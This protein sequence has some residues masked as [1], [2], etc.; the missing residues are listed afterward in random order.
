MLLSLS[1]SLA[2][3]AR[4]A[5]EYPWGLVILTYTWG[6]C[7]DPS[8]E[9]IGWA[10]SRPVQSGANWNPA[11]VLEQLHQCSVCITFKITYLLF[12]NLMHKTETGTARGERLLIA[13]HLDQLNHL[14]NKQ[15]VLVFAVPSAGFSILCKNAV[16]KLFCWAKLACFD[17]SS[18]KI[19]CTVHCWC[20]SYWHD[21][22]GYF[23]Y[24]F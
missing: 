21:F 16:L 8:V 1:C 22:S 12:L 6:K 23:N 24:G 3:L 15:Q 2:W 14:A 7:L 9:Y 17:F 10:T 4:S 18:F 20:C 13:T 19:C 11:Y 5:V